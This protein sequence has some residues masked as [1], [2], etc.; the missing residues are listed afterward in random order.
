MPRLRHFD[1]LQ[2]ARAVNFSCYHRYPLLTYDETI[3]IL[4][5]EINRAR[6]IRHFALLGY[7]IMPTHVHFVM[8]PPERCALGSLIGEMKSRSAR[9]ILAK[10][11]MERNPLLPA[12]RIKK[13]GHMKYV[14]WQARCYDHN[15]RTLEAVRAIIDYCHTNPVKAGLVDDPARWLWSSYRWYRGFDGCPIEIDGIDLL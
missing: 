4:I 7:V 12:L 6:S 9:R 2:T 14:F 11:R 13:G 1:N 3:Q 10:W 8:V 15:C 5:E